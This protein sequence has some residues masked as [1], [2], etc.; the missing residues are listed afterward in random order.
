MSPAASIKVNSTGNI[1]AEQIIINEHYKK[2]FEDKVKD[3][4]A[5]H[6]SEVV[7]TLHA[8]IYSKK[9]S[10]RMRPTRIQHY[11]AVDGKIK[12]AFTFK[13]SKK[14]IDPR[15]GGKWVSG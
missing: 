10:S 2:A 13:N 9:D 7:M 12:S 4:A 1:V 15:P 3:Y 5:S 6:P 8:P 11:L 14:D